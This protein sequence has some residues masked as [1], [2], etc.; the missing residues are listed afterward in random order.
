M[1]R[2][3]HHRAT[4]ILCDGVRCETKKTHSF[5]STL[6]TSLNACACGGNDS[7]LEKGR[8]VLSQV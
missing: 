6:Y 5:Y 7:L 2:E 3:K 1:E 8:S 4:R